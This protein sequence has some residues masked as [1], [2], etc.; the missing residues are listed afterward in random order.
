MNL[1]KSVLFATAAGFISVSGA[2]AADLPVKAK[3]VEYVKICSLYGAGFYYIPGTDMCIKVGGYVRT[4]AE[5][6]SVNGVSPGTNG[7]SGFATS[8][9]SG[10]IG[11]IANGQFDRGS[12]NF[13]MTGRGVLTVDARN[14]SEYGTVR[15]YIRLGGQSISNGVTTPTFFFERAFI[16]FAGFTAG[17]TQSFFDIFT[18]TERFNYNESKT[19]GDTYNY[20]VDLVGYTA[21]FGNG[22]SASV[23]AESP[24]YLAT[25]AVVDGT[26]G[27]FGL[28]TTATEAAGHGMPDIVGQLRIDQNWG[29]LGISGAVHQVAGRYFGTSGVQAHPED[30]YGWAAQVGGELNLPWADTVGAGFVWTKGA[31]G[32]ATKAG[33]WQI[34][35]GS[36]SGLGWL[37]DGIYDGP[38]IPLSA[39]TE[40]HLTNAW[41]ANAAYEH[42]WNSRWRTSLYGGYTKVWYDGQITNDIN[43]HLPGAAGIHSVRRYRCWRGVAAGKHDEWRCWEQQL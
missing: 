3:P 7:P 25:S 42:F 5:W 1:G 28:G 18:T 6:G 35:N 10:A 15:G 17:R 43:T 9:S 36:S 2:Q 26:N 4:Q 27:A 37:T 20:G 32:Y 14:Q 40:I 12:N 39:N 29:Y 24:H 41:S 21:Q 8:T 34:I 19:S 33:S 22:L 13:N 23:S 11:T 30:K 38:G 31:V 16:Q